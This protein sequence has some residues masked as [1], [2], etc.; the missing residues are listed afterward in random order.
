MQSSTGGA[1]SSSK[2]SAQKNKWSVKWKGI[3]KIGEHFEKYTSVKR[4]IYKWYKELIAAAALSRFNR[5]RLCAT[6]ETAAHQAPLSLGFSRREHWSGLPFP[7]PMHESVKWKWSRSVM[8]D[9]SW[10]HVLQPTRLFHPWDFTG[11]STGV[12]CHC[13]LW[14][15]SLLNS[16]KNFFF[17]WAE[18]LNRYFAKEDMQ[19][20]NRYMKK[21]FMSLSIRKYKSKSHLIPVI[22]VVDAVHSLSCVQLCE[23]MDCGMPGSSVLHYLPKFAQL[24]VHWVGD[25][26]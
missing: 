21:G 14:R 23:P 9:S 26:I 5:V 4:L 2:T 17:K 12:G 19:M 20:A 1:I 10:P 13:L 7:S 8:S 22:S 16:K 25:A 11:K 18:V 3:Y 15:N 24:H 6:P